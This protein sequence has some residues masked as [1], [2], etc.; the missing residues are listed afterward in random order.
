MDN[1]QRGNQARDLAESLKTEVILPMG[2]TSKSYS[3]LIK[4]SEKSLKK[5]N[6]EYS[7]YYDN[8][9]RSLENYNENDNESKEL[10]ITK[11]I[12]RYTSEFSQEKKNKLIVK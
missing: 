1:E 3:E 4:K 9:K 11:N 2:E 5:L 12:Y 10:I 6:K 8:Y 7:Y